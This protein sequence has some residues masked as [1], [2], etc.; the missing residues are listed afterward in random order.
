MAITNTDDRGLKKLLGQKQPAIV[1]LYDKDDKPL[2]DAMQRE[3]KKR[4]D[5]LLMLAVDVR[6][7]PDT[8]ARYDNPALPAVIAL[9]PAFFGRKVKSVAQNARPADV[10][11]HIAHL[12]EDAPLPEQKQVEAPKAVEKVRKAT[13]VTAATWRKD[14]L[15]SKTPVLVDFWAAW[16][17]PCQTVAPFIDSLAGKYSGQVKV[18]KLNV[19]ENQKLAQE[20][21]VQSIP[22]FIVFENGQAVGRLSGANPRAIEGLIQGALADS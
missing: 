17:G 12:L 6:Q 4:G 3:A 2:M 18:V 5:E 8:P 16:C 22:T 15:K 9:T 14:V 1:L 20:F 21:N 19:D 10:R 7:N 11:A 13:H